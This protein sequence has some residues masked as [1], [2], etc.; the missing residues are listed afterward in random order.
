MKITIVPANSKDTYF[1][2]GTE[3]EL[4]G[5]INKMMSNAS[6]VQPAKT[7]KSLATSKDHNKD[8]NYAPTTNDELNRQI[9]NFLDSVYAYKASKESLTG[10]GRYLAQNI[11][12]FQPHSIDDLIN[13][14]GI[15][16]KT[17]DRNITKMKDA[18]AR[19]AISSTHVTLVELPKKAR[20]NKHRTVKIKRQNPMNTVQVNPLAG[21]SLS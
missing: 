21:L 7:V 12:D 18:G 16:R 3:A 5:I 4:S 8:H 20:V 15:V 9:N 2:E 10:R 11:C 17:F 1:I 19:F 6:A 13:D 14:A